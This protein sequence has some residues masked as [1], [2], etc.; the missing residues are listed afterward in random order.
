[1]ETLTLE[2]LKA[3][4]AREGQTLTLT[5]VHHIESPPGEAPVLVRE[6][7]KTCPQI[8]LLKAVRELRRSEFVL[9]DA[10]SRNPQAARG[11]LVTYP[12]EDGTTLDGKTLKLVITRYH[13][14]F[15]FT[16][17]LSIV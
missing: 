13:T 6:T 12:D 9:V 5:D 2:E 16:Y 10:D 14:K 11:W 17:T 1:M 7:V 3:L 4:L 15:Y 8:G